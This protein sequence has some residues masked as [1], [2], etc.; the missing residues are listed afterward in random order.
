M[1]D[2][3]DNHLQA[4]VKGQSSQEAIAVLYREVL[5]IL[6]LFST[7]G[8]ADFDPSWTCQSAAYDRK[9]ILE[10]ECAYFV[11]AFLR[12]HLGLNVSPEDLESDFE[13]LAEGALSGAFTGLMHRDF[14][15]RNILFHNSRPRIID[16]QGARRGPI[17]YDVAS[18]LIDPYTG[19]HQPLQDDLF[20][21]VMSGLSRTHRFNLNE[22]K[23]C[24]EF[25]RI[26]RSLQMLG[27]FGYLSRVKGK[28]Q[29]EQ[30]IPPAVNTLKRN[31]AKLDLP[32]VSNLMKIVNNL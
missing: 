9:L 28:R 11:D 16:F 25:C 18:L 12:G 2:V 32:D 7:T 22:F 15:S 21:Y 24:Y 20:D 10:R 3:G 23:R 5:D 13:R 6:I 4:E 19:L 14:Q 8:L 1:E 17:Q 27:A 29:F 26:T 30:Y 31:L